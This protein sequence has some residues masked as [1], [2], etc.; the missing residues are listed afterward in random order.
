MFQRHC[1]QTL[2]CQGMYNVYCKLRLS[3]YNVDCILQVKCFCVC[4][5][6]VCH[7]YIML[8]MMSCFTNAAIKPLLVRERG[9]R[10]WMKTHK[11]KTIIRRHRHLPKMFE[12][13]WA[14]TLSDDRVIQTQTVRGSTTRR[15]GK[16]NPGSKK[17]H[18]QTAKAWPGE[19]TKAPRMCIFVC[20]GF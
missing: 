14:W 17:F 7:L 19:Q 3:W 20:M 4:M 12:E 15:Q 16:S 6:I 13:T 11:I 8:I 9:E 10:S 18:D 5:Y 1:W 2:N